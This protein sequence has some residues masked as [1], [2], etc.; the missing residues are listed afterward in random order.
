V[1]G[2]GWYLVG[3]ILGV[4]EAGQMR[5]ISQP[6]VPSVWGRSLR[7][8]IQRGGNADVCIA[9]VGG[10]LGERAEVARGVAKFVAECLAKRYVAFNLSD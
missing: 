9:P 5:Y 7:R 4:Q 8:P 2:I 3:W 1:K 6:N 10:E